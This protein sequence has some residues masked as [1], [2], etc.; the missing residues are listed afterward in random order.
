MADISIE[1]PAV[2]TPVEGTPAEGAQ[3]V[4]VPSTYFGNDGAL[5]DGWQNT[6][7]ESLRT[8][9]SL[10]TFKSVNDLAKS[11]VNTKSMVGKNTMEVPTESSSEEVWE[12]FYKA[13]GRPDTVADYNLKAPDDFPQELLEQ[14]F[15]KERLEAWQERFYKA[16]ISKKAAENLINEFAKDM[17]ADYQAIKQTEEMEKAEL[18]RN[19]TAEWG[20]AFEQNKHLGNIAV[21]E[22]TLGDIDFK[23]RLVQKFG[24]DP[25]FIKYSSNLGRK[26]AEGKSPNFTNIPTPADYQSQIDEIMENPLYLN[27]TREQRMKL[28]NRIMDIRKKMKPEKNT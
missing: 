11:F 10:A 23:N 18:I 2:G 12:A 20:V 27:G 4:E 25:D 21:E 1:T 14:A 22:G 16:G 24:N 3:A 5:L 17:L 28:A 15:P 8:E 19:L 7:D 26:F 13:G 6:L 9:K